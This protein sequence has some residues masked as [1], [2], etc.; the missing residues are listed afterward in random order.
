MLKKVFLLTAMITYSSLAIEIQP[1]DNVK[2]PEDIK[3]EE[4]E[5]VNK[6]KAP[7]MN[8]RD[9][10]EKENQK[11]KNEVIKKTIYKVDD[12]D[13]KR[14]DIVI[15]GERIKKEDKES[16][17]NSANLNQSTTTAQEK[18]EVLYQGICDLGEQ[19]EL[20]IEERYVDAKCLIY[21][22]TDNKIKNA[23]IVLI[24]V[25]NEYKVIGQIESIDSKKVKTVRILS[26]DRTTQNVAYEIDKKTIANILTLA[27]G[28]TG[29]DVSQVT[30]NIFQQGARQNT[31]IGNTNV[32]ADYTSERLKQ[33][34][35][36]S[37][38]L[39]LA[40]LIGTSANEL[41][42]N[43]KRIPP[44]FKTYRSLYVEYLLE[45]EGK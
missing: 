9:R 10:Q 24:P 8:A 28:Q 39:A 27:A 2:T 14:E 16:N 42:G 40:N 37:L 7:Q 15:V 30:K 20:S 11:Y 32:Q 31:Y 43:N 5:R 45:E 22:A 35:K 1:P 3:K 6:G 18:K 25:A 41:T 26:P 33:V 17:G 34:P 23:R 19:V 4:I 38:Y 12:K 44:L 36:A 21:N 13:L 29:K